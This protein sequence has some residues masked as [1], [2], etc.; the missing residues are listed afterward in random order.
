MCAACP[1]LCTHRHAVA[2]ALSYI[3]QSPRWCLVQ[4]DVPYLTCTLAAAHCLLQSI[5]FHCFIHSL[6]HQ[7]NNS[8]QFH[9]SI[10]SFVC[11]FVRSFMTVDTLSACRSTSSPRRTQQPSSGSS[12]GSS[13]SPPAAKAQLSRARLLMEAFLPPA[14]ALPP[15]PPPRLSSSPDTA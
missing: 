10:L 12:S 14:S 7:F 8:I 15:P 2:I 9:S 5:S 4:G 3:V 1:C 11:L 6:N 13:L